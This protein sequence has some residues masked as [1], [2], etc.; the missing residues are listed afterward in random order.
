MKAVAMKA[1]PKKAVKAA[2]NAMKAAP[3]MKAAAPAKK[4]A[5]PKAVV[6]A[7]KPAKPVKPRKAGALLTKGGMA[8]TVAEECEISNVVAGKIIDSLAGL[9]TAEVKKVGKFTF[10]GLCMIKTRYKPATKAVKKEVFGEM[11]LLKA[12]PARTIVKA[13][14]VSALKKSI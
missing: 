4:V 13:Y 12:R 7:A 8:K 9:A 11:R 2:P 10:P 6:K 3:A 1:A 5:A 14:P